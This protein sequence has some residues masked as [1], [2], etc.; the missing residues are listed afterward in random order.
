MRILNVVGVG[1]GGY[2]E[3]TPVSAEEDGGGADMEKDD[4]VARADVVVDSPADGIGA[5][6]GEVDGDADLAAGAGSGSR[7]GRWWE[8]VMVVGG[9]A[10][11]GRV[12]D[13]NGGELRVV[14]IYW[15]LLGIHRVYFFYFFVSLGKRKEMKEGKI[16][17]F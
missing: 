3:G 13:P 11:G 1:R 16:W 10:W 2:R 15:V 8:V 12:V 7:G 14:W 6:V 5:L 17:K 4:S 9:V